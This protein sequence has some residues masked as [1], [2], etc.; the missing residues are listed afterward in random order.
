MTGSKKRK[1]CQRVHARSG[2]PCNLL[3]GHPGLHI[4]RL[5]KKILASWKNFCKNRKERTEDY[6]RRMSP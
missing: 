1:D 4:A 5:G 6:T 2:Y 3:A